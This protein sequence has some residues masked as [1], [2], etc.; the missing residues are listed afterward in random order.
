MLQ[1]FNGLLQ[2]VLTMN[3][4]D[5]AKALY[6]ALPRLG[7]R[8]TMIAIIQKHLDEFD[9][10]RKQSLKVAI[11]VYIR[12]QAKTADANSHEWQPNQASGITD[13]NA[14]YRA[15]M[16]YAYNDILNRLP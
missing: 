4:L 2:K 3:S 10:D 5:Q 12:E 8:D 15:G 6:L 7:H 14:A 13:T 16:W 1:M 9:R 11:K